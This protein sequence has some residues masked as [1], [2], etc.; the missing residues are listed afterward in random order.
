MLSYLDKIP[1]CSRYVL[2]GQETDEFPFPVLLNEAKPVIEYLDGWKQDISGVRRWEDLPAAAQRYVEYVER[3]IGCH[4]GYV[5]VG[6]E[7]DSII[8]R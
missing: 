6:P 2:D 4:I 3:E 7:R 5:S 1:V 8:I